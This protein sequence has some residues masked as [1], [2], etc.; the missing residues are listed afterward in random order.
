MTLDP[1]PSDGLPACD[2]S[3][4]HVASDN[5][6]HFLSSTF[7]HIEKKN[8]HVQTI[9]CNRPASTQETKNNLVD[10]VLDGTK[11]AGPERLYDKSSTSKCWHVCDDSRTVQQRSTLTNCLDTS[12]GKQENEVGN[13]R[14]PT[15][16]AHRMAVGYNFRANF[17]MSITSVRVFCGLWIY[18][19][20]VIQP[21]WII[22]R[23]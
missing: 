8:G 6:Y 1:R 7:K 5:S 3:A 14:R 10:L 11:C 18:E 23:I 21:G 9:S 2:G 20:R 16:A 15:P 12:N 22:C 19:Y 17:K 13:C 4:R